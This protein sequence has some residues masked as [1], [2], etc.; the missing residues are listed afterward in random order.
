M[1]GERFARGGRDDSRVLA[2]EQCDSEPGLEV[3]D[4]LAR[5]G[6]DDVLTLCGSC[7][8]AVFNRTDEEL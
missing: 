4:A 2:H 6:G 7:D 5:R 1:S 8:A 3:T